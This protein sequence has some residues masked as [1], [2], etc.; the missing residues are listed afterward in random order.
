MASI[1]GRR[2]ADGGSMWGQLRVDAGWM[3]GGCGADTGSMLGQCGVDVGSMRGS[4]R[5]RCWAD[6]GSTDLESI[7]LGSKLGEFGYGPEFI[8]RRFRVAVGY[9]GS[10][11]SATIRDRS[12][13]DVGSLTAHIVRERV[14]RR[15]ALCKVHGS[16]ANVALPSH[17]P[18]AMA[19]AAVR[20]AGGSPQTAFRGVQRWPPPALLGRARARARGPAP[21]AY[22]DRGIQQT[23]MA[24]PTNCSS[25]RSSALRR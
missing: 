16:S 9:S 13:V 1:W 3:R 20:P 22:V 2:G 19:A 12:R 15:A 5:D 10:G 23:S 14:P 17:A 8:R 6:V 24:L 7:C 18:L 21:G 11:H 4:M 25:A